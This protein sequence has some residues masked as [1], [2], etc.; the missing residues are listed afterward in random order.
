MK[1]K[2][3]IVAAPS[4]AGKS[5]FVERVCKEH[6]RLEDT[7]TYTTRSMRA[8]ESQGKPYFFVTKDELILLSAKLSFLTSET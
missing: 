7:V 6:E 5:S 4:G 2:I 8:G 3:I 1:T